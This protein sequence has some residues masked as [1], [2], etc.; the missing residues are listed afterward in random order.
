MLKRPLKLDLFIDEGCCHCGQ[1]DGEITRSNAIECVSLTYTVQQCRQCAMRNKSASAWCELF[2]L[3]CSNQ[4][5]SASGIGILKQRRDRARIEI[6]PESKCIEIHCEARV[7]DET[8]APR[9]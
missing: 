7:D 6:H 1:I 3:I 2:V 9:W 8:A 5:G 4:D